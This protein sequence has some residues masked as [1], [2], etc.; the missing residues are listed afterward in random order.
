[1]IGCL[2]ESKVVSTGVNTV[3]VPDNPRLKSQPW[4]YVTLECEC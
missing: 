3:I 4:A 1:M 2:L